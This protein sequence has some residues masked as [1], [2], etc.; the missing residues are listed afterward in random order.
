MRE[1]QDLAR[2]TDLGDLEGQVLLWQADLALNQSDKDVAAVLAQVKQ[3]EGV[4]PPGNA[5]PV[6]QL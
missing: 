2:R 5:P 3:L 6:G 4:P 1:V